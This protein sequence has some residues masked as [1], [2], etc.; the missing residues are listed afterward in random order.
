MMLQTQGISVNVQMWNEHLEQTIV[1]LHGFTGS[2]A[3]WD[4]VA[5]C[6]KDYRIVAIDLI[7][8]GQT[9][10]PPHVEAYTMEKQI[11]QLDETFQ[12]LNLHE[13]ILLGYSMGGRVALSYA[14][15]FPNRVSQLILESASPGLKSEE[16]RT[17][18]RDSDES[19]ANRIETNGM[20]SF[21]KMWEDIPLFATQKKLPPDVQQTVRKERL[22]QSEVGLANSLRGMG[23]GAQTSLWSNLGEL[24]MP[25]TLITGELDQKF[26]KIAEEMQAL[27]PNAR[28]LKVNEAGHAIHVENPEQFA[29]IVKDA[30]KIKKS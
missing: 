13:V 7:G 18:R 4:K 1:M 27:L 8:H 21:V 19:L 6:I 14:K 23:T 29:T 10:S 5:P 28:H 12:Q 9:D 25:V 17:L 2:V 24:S 26:C 22:S 20:E 16:E 3:T 30:I 11:V 15:T